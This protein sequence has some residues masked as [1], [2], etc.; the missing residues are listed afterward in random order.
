MA[1]AYAKLLVS[2]W[3]PESDFPTLSRNAQWLYWVLISQPALS[4]AGVLPL[5]PRKWA[6]RASDADAETVAEALE[7][8]V[9][10]GFVLVD[11]GTEEALVRTFI[12][13]DGGLNN[14]KI[15]KGIVSAID[16]IESE[17]LKRVA[18]AVF[19]GEATKPHVEGQ[20]QDPSDRPSEEPSEGA[21]QA[22]FHLPP[23]TTSAEPSSSPRK[24]DPLY[25]ALVTACGMDYD[26]M[27]AKQ[28]KSTGVARAELAKVHATAEQ[29]TQRAE[30]YKRKYPRA[31]LTPHALANNWAALKPATTPI[32][33]RTRI[34]DGIAYDKAA[35]W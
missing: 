35:T 30:V 26:E 1:R 16:K 12:R 31:A 32:D 2:T 34:I 27:T 22:T 23:S 9:R 24:P 6:G 18:R 15:R 8:L 28:R 11:E 17:A 4:N 7:E 33:D 5:Q 3:D 25:D 10:R 21:W 14:S 20:D 29:V 13:H 19:D